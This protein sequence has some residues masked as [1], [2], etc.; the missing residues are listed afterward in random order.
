MKNFGQWALNNVSSVLLILALLWLVGKPHAEDFIETTVD[1]RFLTVE[2]K[3]QL[4][5]NKVDALESAVKEAYEAQAPILDN[6][7]E[8][9]RLLQERRQ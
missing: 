9:I 3:Q 4:I 7:A 8:I 2:T 5:I 6:Q 1:K